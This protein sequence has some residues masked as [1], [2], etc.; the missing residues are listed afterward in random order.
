MITEGKRMG[1]GK[2][3]GGWLRYLKKDIRNYY[4]KSGY[5]GKLSISAVS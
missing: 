4:Y 1:E 3:G 5:A 2:D